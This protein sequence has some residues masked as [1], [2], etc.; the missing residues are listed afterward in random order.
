MTQNQS[1]HSVSE[2]SCASRYPAPRAAGVT[3]PR[4]KCQ[5]QPTAAGKRGA[6]GPGPGVSAWLHL[7]I[8]GSFKHAPPPTKQ[9]KSCWTPCRRGLGWVF[10]AGQEWANVS[11]AHP[12]DGIPVSLEARDRGTDPAQPGVWSV[13]AFSPSGPGKLDPGEE[14][15]RWTLTSGSRACGLTLPGPRFFRQLGGSS[16][17]GLCRGL[18]CEPGPSAQRKPGRK[19]KVV[20]HCCTLIQLLAIPG[21][22]L[23]LG[24]GSGQ[25]P[26]FPSPPCSSLSSPTSPNQGCPSCK[27]RSPGSRPWGPPVL[28]S[29]EPPGL[30]NLIKRGE[31]EARNPRPNL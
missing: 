6:G 3:G 15:G 8:G 2:K 24:F 4:L 14:S 29:L 20:S 16:F 1:C 28:S 11:S 12:D 23:P 7:R 13:R 19:P 9:A 31:W 17:S 22:T 5:E 25:H 27:R 21:P 30:G 26:K 18:P 10:F